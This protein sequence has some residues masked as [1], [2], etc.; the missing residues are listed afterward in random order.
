[1]CGDAKLS[2]RIHPSDIS[3]S[4]VKQFMIDRTCSRSVHLVHWTYYMSL[5]QCRWGWVNLKVLCTIP[6]HSE[7][8]FQMFEMV[9]KRN[10]PIWDIGDDLV[11]HD[12]TAESLHCVT[13]AL[14]R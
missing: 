4:I 7:N 8:Q 10:M 5:H 1:M 2:F 12:E 6:S 13:Y 14:K 11:S 3:I 9:L